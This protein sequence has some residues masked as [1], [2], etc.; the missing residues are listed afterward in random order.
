M[1]KGHNDQLNIARNHAKD[2]L[3]SLDTDGVWN[4]IEEIKSALKRSVEELESLERKTF[5]LLEEFDD[6]TDERDPDKIYKIFEGLLDTFDVKLQHE[7][8]QLWKV[9]GEC[10]IW[11]LIGE[12]RR[13]RLSR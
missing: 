2:L 1:K 7:I 6:L 9:Y 10:G 4:G 12:N 5:D 13:T 11:T 3:A 8:G